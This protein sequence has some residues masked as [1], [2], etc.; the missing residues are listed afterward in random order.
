MML[1]RYLVAIVL[2]SPLSLSAAVPPIPRVIISAEG[3]PPPE[4]DKP[5]TP[6][7]PDDPAHKVEQIA[8]NA[9][10]IGDRLASND[11]SDRTLSEQER[12]KKDL[13]DLIK[14]LE[15][16]PMSSSSPMSGGGG[17]GGGGGQQS[18]PQGG[19]GGGASRPMS[20]QGQPMPKPGQQ[21][22]GG[23]PQGSQQPMPG[24]GKPM[25]GQGQEQGQGKSQPESPMGG[26]PSKGQ[27][28]S[29]MP[30]QPGTNPGQGT[31]PPSGPGG[32]Q[33]GGGG[34]AKPALPLDEAIA[35]DFW[36][37]LP[38]QPRQRMLQFFREQYMSRY[39][40]L[41]PQYYQSLAEKEKKG[42]K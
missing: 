32:N 27:G 20:G 10:G 14:S 31:Q 8:K 11:T 33:P 7:D 13:D 5:E 34:M 15:N 18:Q 41:L 36:G 3:L 26:Q 4:D 42:K 19:G 38:D 6:E 2:F 9:R 30:A 16:P 17:G 22:G 28:G 39:K 35:R 37:N 24:G 12:L 29:P 25:P 40:E 21:S 23:S 1:T